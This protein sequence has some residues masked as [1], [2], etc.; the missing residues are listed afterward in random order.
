MGEDGQE[1][2]SSVFMIYS[3]YRGM[4]VFLQQTAKY[5]ADTPMTGYYDYRCIWSITYG[6]E[7][8]IT[9]QRY[10][11]IMIALRGMKRMV[12]RGCVILSQSVS[13]VSIL[14]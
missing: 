1:G 3:I 14:A 7:H 6:I 13:S 9:A 2:K 10:T 4:H 5:S 11:Y 8:F 12:A